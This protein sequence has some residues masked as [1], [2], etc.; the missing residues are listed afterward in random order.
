[1]KSDFKID[2]KEFELS[3]KELA[4]ETDLD[5]PEELNKAAKDV[6]LRA[7]GFTKK[8]ARSAIQKWAT[9]PMIYRLVSKERREKGEG[10]VDNATLQQIIQKRI[11]RL[12]GS[13]GY[14]RIGWANAARAFGAAGKKDKRPHVSEAGL[15]RFGYGKKASRNLLMATFTNTAT[16]SETVAFPALQKAIDFKAKDILIRLKNRLDK[17]MKAHSR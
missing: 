7:W 14:I 12:Y 16:G 15:A 10:A 13:I 2:Y 3:L 9:P 8:A 1:M 5:W 17:R 11:R 6:I 4:K